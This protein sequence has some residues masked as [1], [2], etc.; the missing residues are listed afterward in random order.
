[1]DAQALRTMQAPLKERYKEQPQAALITL[2]AQGTL[3]EG[4]A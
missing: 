1:M 3:G 2:R 4:I